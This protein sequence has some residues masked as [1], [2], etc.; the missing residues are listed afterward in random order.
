MGK[1]QHI[2]AH[3]SAWKNVNGCN[4]SFETLY[5]THAYVRART[6]RFVLIERDDS[7]VAVGKIFRSMGKG[8]KRISIGAARNARISGPVRA[9]EPI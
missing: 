5:A 4:E 8:E 3:C 6:K 9:A 1:K 2:G 7:L